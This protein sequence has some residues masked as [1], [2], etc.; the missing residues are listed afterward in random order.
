VERLHDAKRSQQRRDSRPLKPS[1]LSNTDE[2]PH[3]QAQIEA[4]G[5]DNQ[6]LVDVLMATQVRASHPAG[7]VDVG[8]GALDELT[9]PALQPL[10]SDAADATATSVS[11]IVVVSP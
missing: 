3:Q 6:S 11:R 1:G 10:P 2:R 7:I 9:T 4:A 8:E 5:M